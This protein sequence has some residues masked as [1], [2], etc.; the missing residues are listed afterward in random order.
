MG[1]KR[2]S[3]SRPIL[4]PVLP[5]SGP[6][7]EPFRSPFL[8]LQG[9]CVVLGCQVRCPSRLSLS[10][11]AKTLAGTFL[12]PVTCLKELST[13]C[14]LVVGQIRCS[15]ANCTTPHESCSR[16]CATKKGAPLEPSWGPFGRPNP[17]ERLRDAIITCSD[18]H[19]EEEL[20][21]TSPKWRNGH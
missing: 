13:P 4:Y 9:A 14:N 8:D 3:S 7:L 18:E 11:A 5:P 17:K 2:P 10:M 19:L 12:I 16:R 21:H 1:P 20:R 15:R 6:L